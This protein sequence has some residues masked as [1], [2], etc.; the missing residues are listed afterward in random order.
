MPIKT[1]A[2]VRQIQ[3]APITGVVIERRFNDSHDQM[4]YHVE[5]GDADGDGAP[6]RHWF[7]ESQIAA[8]GEGA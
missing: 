5:S 3:P 2:T 1:G 8:T 4:E 7:L 6:D